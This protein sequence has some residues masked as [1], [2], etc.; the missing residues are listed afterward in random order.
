[1]K[2]RS[3]FLLSLIL[4]VAALVMVLSGRGQLEEGFRAWRSGDHEMF[5]QFAHRGAWFLYPAWAFAAAGVACLFV[6][7]RRRERACRWTVVALLGLFLLLG[8]APV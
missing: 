8:L 5:R 2:T 3:M 1:M 7:Y 6:S 4:V